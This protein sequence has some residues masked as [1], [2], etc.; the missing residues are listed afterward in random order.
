VLSVERGDNYHE[1]KYNETYMF[2]RHRRGR[3]TRSTYI[4]FSTYG[5]R[6]GGELYMSPEH[7]KIRLLYDRGVGF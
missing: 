6:P 1:T 4:Y 5:G 7:Q 3:K 2:A